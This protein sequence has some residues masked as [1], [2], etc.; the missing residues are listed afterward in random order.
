[1]INTVD[2]APIAVEFLRLVTGELD[3]YTKNKGNVVVNNANSISLFSP[4]HIQ[5]AKYGRGK[6]KT[7]FQPIYDWV[8]ENSIQFEGLSQKSTAWAIVKSISKN[9]TLN[10]VPNAPNAIEEA[11]DL[12]LDEFNR[13]VANDF[14]VII[15]LEVDDTYRKSIGKEF[16]IR[17]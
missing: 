3:N 4:S 17:L 9:G 13:K 6:G 11:I 12:H 5:F 14:R 8:V 15:A 16:K 2:F 7:P 10:Y 1:M